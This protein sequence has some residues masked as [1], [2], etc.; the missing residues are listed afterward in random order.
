MSFAEARRE[1]LAATL[2][3]R[4]VAD[5]CEHA[6]K[7]AEALAGATSQWRPVAGNQPELPHRDE[8]V[9]AY[10]GHGVYEL[11][12]ADHLEGLGASHWM[13]LPPHPVR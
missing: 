3:L 5:E 12:R 7:Q 2:A 13:P 1:L 11:C 10:L 8:I 4:R 6:E 9:L